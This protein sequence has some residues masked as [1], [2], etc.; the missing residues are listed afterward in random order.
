M[1]LLKAVLVWRV[2]IVEED[3]TPVGGVSMEESWL[4][5]QLCMVANKE[6]HLP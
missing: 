1:N 6:V 3:S 5:N 2:Q 4:D